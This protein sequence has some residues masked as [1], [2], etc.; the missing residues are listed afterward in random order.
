MGN[1]PNVFYFRI[2]GCKCFVKN[3]K[4]RLGKF[5]TRAIEGIFVGYVNE[6][7]AYRY[8]N[9]STRR[10]E[11]SCDGEFEDNNGSNVEQVIP[12]DVGDGD[13]SQ[14]IKAMGVGHVLPHEIHQDQ[15]N[16]EEQAYS[17]QVMPSITQFEP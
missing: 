12:I 9:K 10:V 2:F 7:H 16:D 8:Y 3:N 6:S 13:P 11:E 14:L 17:T 1:K 15:A 4:E 5:K